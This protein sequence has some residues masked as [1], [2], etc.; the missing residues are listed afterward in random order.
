MAWFCYV[1][2]GV[3]VSPKTEVS[4]DF[5]NSGGLKPNGIIKI[6]GTEAGRIKSVH[7]R[8]GK[9]DP[10]LRRLDKRVWVRVQALIDSDKAAHIHQDAIAYVAT[11]SMLG[12]KYIEMDLGDPFVPSI[13]TESVLLGKAPP[14]LDQ[15]YRRMNEIL[16]SLME[17]VRTN[18]EF[19]SQ[20]L[21][22]AHVYTE[23]MKNNVST[24]RKDLDTL[25]KRAHAGLDDVEA[26]VQKMETAVADLN[27]GLATGG[28]FKTALA[29][30]K[31]QSGIWR[32]RINLVVGRTRQN[33]RWMTT[34]LTAAHDALIDARDELPRFI[35]AANAKMEHARRK[36][37]GFTAPDHAIGQYL[38]NPDTY[39]DFVEIVK[40]LKKHP[41]KFMWKN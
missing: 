18:P 19:I 16:S 41:W 7:Y 36:M 21:N 5:N 6:L 20:M 29:S 8:G 27:Q 33:L 25:L 38:T 39:D 22:A 34:K 3:S 11:L 2:S 24:V 1:L 4:I 15:V 37:E 9:E 32:T 14:R 31:K 17:L 26:K 40:D 30:F 35:A 28:E 10:A 23:T 13:T 12:D